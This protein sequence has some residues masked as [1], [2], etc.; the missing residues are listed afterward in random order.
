MATVPVSLSL[1]AEHPKRAEQTM[2]LSLSTD[3]TAAEYMHTDLRQHVIF[4]VGPC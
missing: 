3:S 1:L 4:A 2:G